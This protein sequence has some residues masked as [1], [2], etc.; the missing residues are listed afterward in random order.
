MAAALAEI[1]IGLPCNSSLGF[2]HR[3]NNDLRLFDE[4]IEAPTGDIT[5]LKLRLLR[6]DRAA[7]GD[8]P[9]FSNLR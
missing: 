7:P 9:G 6:S 1:A 2:G 4:V 3:F 8:R 5:A